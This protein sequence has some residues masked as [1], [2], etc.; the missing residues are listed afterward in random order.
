MRMKVLEAM[1][2]TL[3]GEVVEGF[4]MTLPPP[5]AVLIGFEPVSV[6]LA[7]YDD[8]T[9]TPYYDSILPTKKSAVAET[10][11][12]TLRAT[13]PLSVRLS[14]K[15]ALLLVLLLNTYGPSRV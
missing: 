7:V 2:R 1:Q 5:V 4:P 13:V 11:T 8:E 9:S 6:E 12:L 15:V 10:L 3:R 14:V